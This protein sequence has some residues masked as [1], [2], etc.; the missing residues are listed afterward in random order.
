MDVVPYKIT[1]GI[2]TG[3]R[4]RVFRIVEYFGFRIKCFHIPISLISQS[5]VRSFRPSLK[6]DINMA[7]LLRRALAY[8]KFA[9]DREPVLV[10]AVV[11]GFS[12]TIYITIDI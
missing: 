10:T 8:A 1:Q 2:F 4:Y 3:K 11:M 9:W 12:G 5:G 7:G 6:V